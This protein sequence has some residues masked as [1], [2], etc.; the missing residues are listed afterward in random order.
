[1]IPGMGHGCSSDDKEP[2]RS[3]SLWLVS[4]VEKGVAPDRIIATQKLPD[5]ATRTGPLCAYPNTA[6]WTGNGSFDDASN[7]VCVDGQ[8]NKKDFSIV[9]LGVADNWVWA[10]PM[11]LSLVGRRNVCSL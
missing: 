6:K 2:F 3:T 11:G 4:W 10:G 7:F 9:K 5:G 8:H 1:M